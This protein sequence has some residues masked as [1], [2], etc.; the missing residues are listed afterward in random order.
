MA[1]TITVGA[2]PSAPS[3]PGP[4]TSPGTGQVRAPDTG[5][6]P[7]SESN[8]PWLLTLV[9]AAAIGVALVTVG[10]RLAWRTDA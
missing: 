10:G 1:G 6:G 4:G 5:M 3:A 7:G 8:G 2:A 9:V